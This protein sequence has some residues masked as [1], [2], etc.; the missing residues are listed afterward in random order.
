MLECWAIGN[1]GVAVGE[2]KLKCGMVVG[3]KTILLLLATASEITWYLEA[4]MFYVSCEIFQLV[5]I[6]FNTYIKCI[7]NV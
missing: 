6:K 1:L 3:N 7:A 4:K 5:S 2:D